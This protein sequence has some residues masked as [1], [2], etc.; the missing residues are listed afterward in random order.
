MKYTKPI[1]LFIFAVMVTSFYSCCN[2]GKNLDDS[3]TVKGVITV[4]GNE[5]FTRLAIQT[6]DD[7]T[8][9]LKCSKELRDELWKHQGSYYVI[10]YGDIRKEEGMNVLIVE[11][12][13][14]IKKENQTK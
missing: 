10:Q 4:V 2:C 14:P 11:K 7:K 6:D 3:N 1:F 8:Y 13:I 9:I 5:P 12:V